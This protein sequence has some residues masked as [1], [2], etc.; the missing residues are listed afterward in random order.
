MIY[1]LRDIALG[2]PG[3]GELL[4]LF[5]LIIVLFGAS[6][7]PKLAKAIRLSLE[8]LNKVKVSNKPPKCASGE[9]ERN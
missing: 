4:I 2:L 1:P 5:A 6:K 8:E 3:W 7:L 9:G